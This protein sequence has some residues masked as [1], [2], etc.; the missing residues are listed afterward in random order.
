MDYEKLL[1]RDWSEIEEIG[2][3]L[4]KV[5]QIMNEQKNFKK[6]NEQIDKELITEQ[7]VEFKNAVSDLIDIKSELPQF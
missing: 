4:I 6:S 7:F 5:S 2:N 3:Q 1:A